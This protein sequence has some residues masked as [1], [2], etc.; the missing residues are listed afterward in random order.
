MSDCY[1]GEIRMFAGNYAPQNW[2]FCSG[3]ILA[4]QQNSS[5]FSL[6]G[7]VYGGDGRTSFALPEMRGR[8]P[9][10]QGKGAGLRNRPL[11][12]KGGL[13]DV[14]LTEFHLPRHTHSL[15]GTTNSADKESP[16][17][18]MLA[19]VSG[20][21]YATDTTSPEAMM[22]AEVKAAGDSQPHNNL[23]PYLGV[24]FIIALAGLYPSR[25]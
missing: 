1:I 12:E 10:G 13:E 19:M 17:N 24:N 9:V 22:S 7:T 20:E 3:A 21:F 8:V 14:T 18:A 23:A 25:N 16:E 6:L 5:L 11:A 4:I 15:Q 2:A